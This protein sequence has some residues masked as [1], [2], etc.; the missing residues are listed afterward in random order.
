[1]TQ[2]AKSPKAALPQA[3]TVIIVGIVLWVA[4]TVIAIAVG[5]IAKII[6]TCIVGA[7]LGLVGLRYTIRRA[8]RSGI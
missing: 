8:R 6:W 1:M 3:V 4:A 2:Q 7:A 5:A